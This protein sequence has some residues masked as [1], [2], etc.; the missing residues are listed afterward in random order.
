VPVIASEESGT[1]PS[2]EGVGLSKTDEWYNAGGEV[3]YRVRRTPVSYLTVR[4]NPAG[5]H[6]IMKPDY[7]TRCMDAVVLHLRVCRVRGNSSAKSKEERRGT[8][9]EPK[10]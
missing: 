9:R 7:K 8:L 5:K 4:A 6:T 10:R 2:R 3:Q 1:H